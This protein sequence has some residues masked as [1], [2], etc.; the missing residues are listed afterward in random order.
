MNKEGHQRSIGFDGG[1]IVLVRR[2][3]L[4]RVRDTQDG[5]SRNGHLPRRSSTATIVA[6]HFSALR[7]QCYSKT[8]S[9]NMS[10]DDILF[11]LIVCGLALAVAYIRADLRQARRY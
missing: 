2:N 11:G 5:C 9:F 7:L 4:P 10:I 1:L 8:M 3:E 6:D